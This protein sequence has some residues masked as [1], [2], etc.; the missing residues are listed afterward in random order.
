MQAKLENAEKALLSL[1]LPLEMVMVLQAQISA[2]AF[3]IAAEK[4]QRAHGQQDQ[5]LQLCTKTFGPLTSK[6]LVA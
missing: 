5:L 6:L 1:A 2:K 4:S 3:L